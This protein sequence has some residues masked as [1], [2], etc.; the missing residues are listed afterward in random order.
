MRYGDAKKAESVPLLQ[1]FCCNCISPGKT[2]S[3]PPRS[4][5]NTQTGRGR[6]KAGGVGREKIFLK[7]TRPILVAWHR[8]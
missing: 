6:V 3:S 1:Y 5:F 4:P 7:E 8:S 2:K